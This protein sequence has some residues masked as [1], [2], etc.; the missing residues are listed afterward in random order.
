M[1]NL[2][3]KILKEE[4]K[5]K[6]YN[7]LKPGVAELHGKKIVVVLD[8]NDRIVAHGPYITDTTD[9]RY[10]CHIVEGLIEELFDEGEIQMESLLKE[11]DTKDFT[12]IQK[13]NYCDNIRESEEINSENVLLSGHKGHTGKVFVHRN[14][15]K[16]P[17][18]TIKAR[19]GENAGI[20]I[21]YDKTV[22]LTN[23]IFS[24]SE[25]SRQRVLVTKQKNVHAGV[26]GYLKEN[27]STNT[28]G[29]IPVTYNPYKYS[30]FIRLDNGQP[31][32]EASEAIL[33]NEKE[34]WVKI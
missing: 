14:L 2:I 15:N 6:K 33:K 19:S 30:T 31:I 29:W 20:V 17:Y 18:W 27:C 24:V 28:S 7:S 13:I 11:L 16:P 3:R 9:K 10:I 32:Y 5:T 21:G 1:K 8:E 23:V 22:C 26:V 34:I 12:N 25:K 4:L